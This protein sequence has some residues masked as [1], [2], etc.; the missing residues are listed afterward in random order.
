MNDYIVLTH[1]VCHLDTPL[2]VRTSDISAFYA[3]VVVT[4]DNKVKSYVN[5]S[6]ERFA[7]YETVDEIQKLIYQQ[8][9][10]NGSGSIL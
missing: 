10:R 7:V 9:R 8:A 1:N 5:C 4:H 2:Y 6:N 3:S